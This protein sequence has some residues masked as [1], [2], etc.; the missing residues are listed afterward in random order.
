MRASRRVESGPVVTV[1]LL[2]AVILAA[3]STP[4]TRRWPFPATQVVNNDELLSLIEARTAKV[5][6]L[7]AE[8]SASFIGQHQSGV[9]ELVSYYQAPDQWRFSAFRDSMLSIHPLFD[10]VVNGKMFRLRQLSRDGESNMRAG[11]LAEL[12]GTDGFGVFAALQA[13]LFL[14]GHRVDTAWRMSADAKRRVVVVE[15]ADGWWIRWYLDAATFGIERAEV[16]RGDAPPQSTIEYLSYREVNGVFLPEHFRIIEDDQTLEGVL[17]L[18]EFNPTL[19]G[20][21]FE[22]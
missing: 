3:C 21:V 13:S 2:L 22:L 4:T 11:K 12:G 10:L 15:A 20:D 17:R 18:V 14:P 1:G 9:F 6:S 16:S 5:Q 19:A 8:L 7:Y